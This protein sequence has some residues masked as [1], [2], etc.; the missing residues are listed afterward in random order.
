MDKSVLIIDDDAALLTLLAYE[1]KFAGFNVYKASSITDGL[2][3]LRQQPVDV[4]LTD[5]HLPDGNGVELVQTIK[6]A[7]P[8]T[9][10]I[11]ITSEGRISDGVRAIKNGAYDYLE[12]GADQQRLATLLNDAS[13]NAQLQARISQLN[14]RVNDENIKERRD[15]ISLNHE[16]LEKATEIIKAIHSP[17]RQRILQLIFKHGKRSVKEIY[18]ELDLPQAIVSQHLA[19]LKSAGLVSDQ[20]DGKYSVYS[21]NYVGI[22]KIIAYTQQLIDSDNNK[23]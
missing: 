19:L 23:A 7:Y 8:H 22:E 2:E 17:L 11:A 12:K 16:Q 21:A 18:L 14:N 13:Q 15:I 1:A 9:E 10:V 5:V 3:Q 4:V 20:R 6:A